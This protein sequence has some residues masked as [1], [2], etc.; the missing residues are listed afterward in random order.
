MKTL[1]ASKFFF[2]GQ[3]A[4]QEDQRGT[5]ISPGPPNLLRA[6]TGGCVLERGNGS[7][8]FRRWQTWSFI[9]SRLPFVYI[10]VRNW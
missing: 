5:G 9:I 2:R 10:I 6:S 3:N 8:K 4:Q 1:K 7:A